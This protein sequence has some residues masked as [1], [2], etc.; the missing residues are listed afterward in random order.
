M[1]YNKSMNSEIVC[2]SLYMFEIPAVTTPFSGKSRKGSV[3]T[4]R[5][6]TLPPG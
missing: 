2:R 6:M 4:V 5:T 1:T 3:K